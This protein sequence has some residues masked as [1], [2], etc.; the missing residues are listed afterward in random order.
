MAVDTVAK[1]VSTLAVTSV[2]LPLPT[3]SIGQDARQT[4]VR[5]YGG[6]LAEAAVA[7][8]KVIR[9]VPIRGIAMI[10]KLIRGKQI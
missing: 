1:R 9:G 6:I 8:I 2:V 3:G 10:G 4:V 5:T 7:V